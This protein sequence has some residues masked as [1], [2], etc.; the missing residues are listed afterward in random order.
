MDIRQV[1]G[2]QTAT[3]LVAVVIAALH[4]CGNETCA[5]T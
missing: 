2:Y 1:V 5:E 4:T 3:E